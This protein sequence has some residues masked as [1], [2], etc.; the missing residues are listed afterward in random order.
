MNPGREECLRNEPFIGPSGR[1]V[2]T[3]FIPG[4]RL[5][6][7]A[8]VYLANIARCYSPIT[9]TGNLIANKHYSACRPYL[10]LDLFLIPNRPIHLVALGADPTRHLCTLLNLGKSRSLTWLFSHQGTPFTLEKPRD[11]QAPEQ[12]TGRLWGTFHPAAILRN[13]SLIL[14]SEQHLNLL[15]SYLSGLTPEPTRPEIAPCRPPLTLP[16]TPPST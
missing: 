8:S 11:G 13:R 16:P 6:T 1:V 2:R 9:P 14:S 10:L 15:S 5:Q 4:T 3:S 7:L 12:I